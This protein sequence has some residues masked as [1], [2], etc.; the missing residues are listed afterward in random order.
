MIQ[1]MTTGK[2]S[3]ILVS[4]AV[5]IILS[6][7][8]QQFYNI[9]DSLIAGQFAGVNAFVLD[10]AP[11]GTYRKLVKVGGGNVVKHIR[12][13]HN[14]GYE[15]GFVFYFLFGLVGQVFDAVNSR[16]HGENHSDNGKDYY[17]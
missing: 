5:P 10:Y 8:F 9:A 13:I 14:N 12:V 7:M 11:Y 3:K 16:A 1:D 4:Y 17:S 6:G 2:P 15:H